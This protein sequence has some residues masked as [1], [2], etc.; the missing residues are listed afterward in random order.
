MEIFVY[1]DASGPVQGK[2]GAG[3]VLCPRLDYAERPRV[4]V[5]RFRAATSPQA[6]A[7]A[8]VQ[9]ARWALDF[10]PANR[11]VVH[12]DCAPA[13]HIFGASGRQAAPPRG[14][15]TMDWK[16][17]LQLVAALDALPADVVVKQVSRQAPALRI[18]DLLSKAARQPKAQP[19]F[20]GG[21]E[22]QRRL[23]TLARHPA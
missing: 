8:I 3:F 5:A 18:A 17:R 19:S 22:L 11:V 7:I 15:L 6:E 23:R 16:W 9:A 21:T 10:V 2:A 4:G 1:A 13:V 14:R 12:S 20:T